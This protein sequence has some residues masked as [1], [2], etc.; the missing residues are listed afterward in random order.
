[1]VGEIDGSEGMAQLDLVDVIRSAART[2]APQI[3][4]RGVEVKIVTLPEGTEMPVPVRLSARAAALIAR[5]LLGQAVAAT[6]RGLSVNVS[7]AAAG[8]APGQ[9]VGPRLTIDDAGASLPST[10]RRAFVALELEPSTFGRPSSIPLF[11]CSELI[12]WQGAILELGDAPEG[13]L[14]VGVHFPKITPA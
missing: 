14:R 11:V 9:T 10:A 2:L 13:G 5:E 3:E 1:M 12:A 7:V 4:R 6:P 8:G